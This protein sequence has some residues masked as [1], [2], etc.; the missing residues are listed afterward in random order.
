MLYTCTTPWSV[1]PA[2]SLPISISTASCTNMDYGGS[3]SGSVKNRVRRRVSRCSAVS[4]RNDPSI[5]SADVKISRE[6]VAWLLGATSAL[7]DCRYREHI[8]RRTPYEKFDIQSI[9]KE[10][11]DERHRDVLYALQ[12]R[13]DFGGMGGDMKWVPPAPLMLFVG[14]RHPTSASSPVFF[15]IQDAQQL[16]STLVGAVQ[17]HRGLQEQADGCW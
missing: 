5:I 13:C 2:H 10:L 8:R 3:E 4:H 7:A 17:A 9:A 14:R 16:H 6:V 1:L 11:S 15:H 12:L